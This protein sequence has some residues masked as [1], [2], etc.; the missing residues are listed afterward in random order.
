MRNFQSNGNNTNGYWK[1]AYESYIP[2][3]FSNIEEVEPPKT[4]P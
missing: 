2:G 4:A 3:A 1:I